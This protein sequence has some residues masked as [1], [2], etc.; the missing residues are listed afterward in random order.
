MEEAL[1]TIL[2]AAAARA[3]PAERVPIEA[4]GGRVLA[5]DV[6]SRDDVPAFDNSGM[7]GYAVRTE[8]VA[9]AS[10]GAP[11]RLRVTGDLPAGGRFEGRVGRG[12][13]VRIMTGAPVPDG[14]DQ[15]VEVE[16]TEALDAGGA[17]LIQAARKQGANIRRAAEDLRRGAAVLRRGQR[18][19]PPEVG[20]LAACGR[21]AVLVSR[22]PR[23]AI[24]STGD[25]VVPPGTPALER[26]QVRDANLYALAAACRA[27]SAEPII[28]G[29]A[30]DR[31]AAIEARLRDGLEQGADALITSAGI[32]VG[33]RDLAR[34]VFL[35]LGFV[36]RFR[37][38][39]MKPGR[40]LSFYVHAERGTPIFAL[41][42]NPVAALV[43]FDLFC[44]A[45]FLTLQGARAIARPVVVATVEEPVDVRPGR[46]NY[47]RARLR[48]DAETGTY[49]VV[50]MLPEGSGLLRTMHL[51]DALVRI[52]AAVPAGGRVRAWLLHAAEV[53]AAVEGEAA[54]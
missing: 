19:G 36:E 38:I 28:L 27:C 17:V 50:E 2:A 1:A 53:E 14:A 30:P 10:A 48:H 9:G 49:R 35:S 32:S 15:V 29:I 18:I 8:D 24:L 34:E 43:C 54:A 31:E 44:R 47:V 5:E 13:A 25:E 37:E 16:R 26:G 23:V 51:A 11:R 40:P 4:A 12:E 41:P 42:G 46:V 45:A 52:D 33:A 20:L 6:E 3:L 39:Q 21:A 7:D 22:R